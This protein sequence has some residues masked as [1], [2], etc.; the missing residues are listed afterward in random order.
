MQ[1]KKPFYI[2]RVDTFLA[3]DEIRPYGERL[4]V[5][6]EKRRKEVALQL[7]SEDNMENSNR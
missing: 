2:T 7:L 6:S 4:H 1:Y 5:S 3:K